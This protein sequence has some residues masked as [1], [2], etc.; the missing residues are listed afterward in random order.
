MIKTDTL[1]LMLNRLA[2]NDGLS[3]VLDNG[4]VN[5]VT[6]RVLVGGLDCMSWVRQVQRQQQ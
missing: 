4:L 5:G 2:V 3:E 1:R 6:L